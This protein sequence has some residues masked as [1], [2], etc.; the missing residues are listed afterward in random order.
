[1]SAREQVVNELT[2]VQSELEEQVNAV[3]RLEQ[4][5]VELTHQNQALRLEL[6][7]SYQS[8]EKVRRELSEKLALHQKAADSAQLAAQS[9]LNELK[10]LQEEHAGLH[11]KALQLEEAN[12]KLSSQVMSLEARVDELS[13]EQ[14]HLHI[15]LRT[16]QETVTQSKEMLRVQAKQLESAE[17]RVRLLQEEAEATVL[18]H[19]RRVEELQSAI[20]QNDDHSEEAARVLRETQEQHQLVLRQLEQRLRLAESAREQVMNELT[21]VQSELEEQVNAV[22]RLEQDAVEL[23]RQ[24]QALRLE[25]QTSHHSTEKV[26]RELSEKLALHQKAADSAQLAAQSTLNELKS[27]QEEHARLRDKALQLEESNLEL[28]AKVIQLEEAES[29]VQAEAHLKQLEIK[30]L[31][32]LLGTVARQKAILSLRAVIESSNNLVLLRIVATAKSKEELIGVGLNP[33]EVKALGNV[34]S[35]FTE[36]NKTGR[37]RLAALEKNAIAVLKEQVGVGG[38][39]L[40]LKVKLATSNEDLEAA[41][42]DKKQIAFLKNKNF[43]THLLKIAVSRLDQNQK[44]IVAIKAIIEKSIDV[45]FLKTLAKATKNEHLTIGLPHQYVKD[46]VNPDVY[47]IF[48][49]LA[50]ER[51]QKLEASQTKAMPNVPKK[52]NLLIEKDGFLGFK[53]DKVK[54]DQLDEGLPKCESSYE[55]DTEVGPL[56]KGTLGVYKGTRVENEEVARS[57]KVFKSSGQDKVTG[58][59][60]LVQDQTGRVVDKSYGKFD[61]QQKTDIA[62]R[63]AQMFLLNYNA[64]NQKRSKKEIYLWG[65]VAGSSKVFA[66]LLY[67]K[68]N[69][70]TLADVVIK[71]STSGFAGPRYNWYTRNKVS[72]QNFIKKHLDMDFLTQKGKLVS[73]Q[74]AQ[75]RK[76]LYSAE[77]GK[78]VPTST[79]LLKNLYEGD[80]LS[81]EGDIRKISYQ[82]AITVLNQQ[83]KAKVKVNILL[84]VFEEDISDIEN[85]K[86]FRVATLLHKRLNKLKEEAFKE[87]IDFDALKQFSEQ[88]KV[89]IE[90]AIPVLEESLGRSY[91]DN[92]SKEIGIVIEKM[93]PLTSLGSLSLGAEKRAYPTRR[94]HDRTDENMPRN[95]LS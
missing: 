53:D 11:D 74:S 2:G 88:S 92:L 56:I 51:L 76:V 30:R 16:E 13:E 47:R 69:D 36:I 67:L 54:R 66:A 80:E 40:L 71:S 1:E 5:A 39:A 12:R 61:L 14:A 26:R 3:R 35:A 52:A 7:T 4:D 75:T 29:R 45:E 91:L 6:Q 77:K 73:E 81:A 34:P 87:P 50:N 24:N 42:L 31:T 79:A 70:P 82:E 57:Q 84:N 10:S 72:E 43:Y 55:A 18:A 15:L 64:D 59:A 58:V 95:G 21:G 65:P 41:G 44:A 25:L 85:D 38:E 27:L 17:V 93:S 63:Q 48:V 28:S 90:Q 32:G 62:L 86:A 33:A 68:H 94:E 23:T 22:R 8:T 49:V 60:L 19:A 9:T 89:V 83:H 20:A 78:S 46:L 37:R